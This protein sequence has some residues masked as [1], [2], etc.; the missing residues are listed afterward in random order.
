MSRKNQV[1]MALIP[2]GW[3]QR[4]LAREMG[5]TMSYLQDLLKGN[6]NSKERLEQIEDLLGIQFEEEKKV[7]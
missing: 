1:K 6:R 3:S 7:G 4:K 5:I 2:L